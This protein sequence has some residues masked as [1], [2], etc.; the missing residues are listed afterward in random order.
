MPSNTFF[1]LP[2][3]KRETFLRSARREFAQ[4]PYSEASINQ[5]IREA[6][7]PRGSFYMYFRDKEDL[8]RYLLQ[9]S[10]DQLMRVVEELLLREQG[11]I[12]HAL[13]MLYDYLQQKSH[14]HLLGD[15]G[16]LASILHQNNGM[17]K[18]AILELVEPGRL[19]QHVAP[20]VNA[21]ALDLQRERDLED[22]LALLFGIT[23]PFLYSSI[24]APCGSSSRDRL[25][26][27]L[28]ILRRG[29][30]K[31]PAVKHAIKE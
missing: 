15:I 4:K 17:Q 20:L 5:I 16:T 13:L 11:D 1:N 19:L 23:I 26:N 10:I 12:F 25:E 27:L 2:E 24:Q 6:G 22:M 3:E 7:I 18:H 28:D 8:F 21:D 14:S 30:S 31:K 29:M 9:G